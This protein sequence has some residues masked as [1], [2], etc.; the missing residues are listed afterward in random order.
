LEPGPTRVAALFIP[1][2]IRKKMKLRIVLFFL[3]TYT[4]FIVVFLFADSERVMRK[5]MPSES[6]KIRHRTY[7]DVNELLSTRRAYHPAESKDA[8][9][10][11]MILYLV[12]HARQ[13]RT[14]TIWSQYKFLTE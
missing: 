7:T 11:G 14:N 5:D 8:C 13:V 3:P 9:F 6:Y 2:R 12:H 10:H 1:S 4:F